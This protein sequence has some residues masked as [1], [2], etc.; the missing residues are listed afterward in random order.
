MAASQPAEPGSLPWQPIVL[1]DGD[2]ESDEPP[3]RSNA[4]A[5]TGGPDERT[6]GTEEPERGQVRMC[7]GQGQNLS[8]LSHFATVPYFQPNP[9]LSPKALRP[10]LA[11][12]WA[13]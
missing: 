8:N 5:A 4:C 12:V 11:G 1:S 9:V 6:D 10:S 13:P 7:R 3:E 2:E